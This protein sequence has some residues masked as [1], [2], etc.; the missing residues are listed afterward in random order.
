MLRGSKNNLMSV[1]ISKDGRRVA[2]AVDGESVVYLWDGIKGTLVNRISGSGKPRFCRDGKRLA[3]RSPDPGHR[4]LLLDAESGRLIAMTPEHKNG[5]GH[6]R[7]S[8][9]G[10]RLVSQSIDYTAWLVDGETGSPI[11]WLT[12]HSAHRPGSSFQPTERCCSPPPRTGPRTL[13]CPNGR[14]GGHT[15]RADPLRILQRWTTDRR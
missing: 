7:F 1:D 6:S 11:A 3:V 10:R 12:G 13:G 14:S 9:D 2:G 15:L 5:V 8:A 4:L